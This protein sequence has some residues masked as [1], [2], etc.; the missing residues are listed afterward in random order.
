MFRTSYG[1]TGA[2]NDPYSTVAFFGRTDGPVAVG[3]TCWRPPLHN[4]LRGDPDQRAREVVGDVGHL[5]P[6]PS[7][8]SGNGWPSCG[9]TKVREGRGNGVASDDAVE[10]SP[11]AVASPLV[12]P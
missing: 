8:T 12:G 2:S 4:G 7:V 1:A 9:A 3:G 11:T 10:S 5:W 6:L